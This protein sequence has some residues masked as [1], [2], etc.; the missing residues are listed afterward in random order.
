MNNSSVLIKGGVV[1]PFNDQ[2]W[3]EYR[4]ALHRFILSRINDP[5]LAED[6]VQ[7]VLVKAYHR[8]DTL[9]DQGK[10][11][12]WLYQITRNAIVDDYRQHRPTEAIDESLLAQE[13]NFG[14]EDEKEL[15][16][17]LLPLV[18]QLPPLYRQAVIWS[19]IEG[20]TQKVVAQKQGITLSG[21]KSRVQRGRHMLKTMLLECCRVELDRRGNL[22]NCEPNKGCADCTEKMTPSL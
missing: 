13:I 17:C 21:A 1:S 8:L 10:I 14:E 16:R 3:T 9:K 22:I 12:P 19:E 18:N 20:L 5:M 11:L 2:L 6:I 4:T 15:A 7:D